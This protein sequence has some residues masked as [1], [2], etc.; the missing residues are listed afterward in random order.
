MNL[1]QHVVTAGAL[2]LGSQNSLN[3]HSVL[4]LNA[5]CVPF[6]VAASLGSHMQPFPPAVQAVVRRV[7]RAVAHGG[8]ECRMG[9]AWL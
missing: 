5:F 8:A 4:T 6:N 3:G 7:R 9:P 1:L 2:L